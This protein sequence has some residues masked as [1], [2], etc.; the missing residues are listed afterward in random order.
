[1]KQIY[2][3]FSLQMQT[4]MMFAIFIAFIYFPNLN[5][6]INLLPFQIN[7]IS[8]RAAWYYIV[9]FGYKT[10]EEAVNNGDYIWIVVDF[11][12]FACFA[13]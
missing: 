1:M 9:I 13:T 11:C 4:L 7:T 6:E 10:G 2:A 8:W 3:L 5:S 12:V